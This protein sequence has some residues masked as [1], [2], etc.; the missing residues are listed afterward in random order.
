VNSYA[1][2]TPRLAE[3]YH[4]ISD[5][6]F[7]GGQKLVEMLGVKAGDRVL[8]VGCG[9]GRLA[10]WIAECVGPDGSVAGIDPLADRIAVAREN[11]R[12]IRFEIGGAE[13]LGCFADAS[14]DFVCL[15]AVFHWI[16]DKPRALAEIQRV[17]R[18]GGRLG[19]T[20]FR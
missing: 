6:Q 4:R 5:A 10:R 13:D 2:D 11:C 12:G 3:T 14:F 7:S 9:T 16:Q 1:H 20:T 17:L 19:G 8:D 18:P 15:N